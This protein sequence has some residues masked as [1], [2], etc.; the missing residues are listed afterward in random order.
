[1]QIDVRD[2]LFQNN[3]GSLTAGA[4]YM[5]GAGGGGNG[6]LVGS[7]LSALRCQFDG[8]QVTAVLGGKGG[9]VELSPGHEA[10]FT[11]SSFTGN[12]AHHGGAML[13]DQAKVTVVSSTFTNNIGHTQAP[14][15]CYIGTLGTTVWVVDTGGIFGPGD[16]V[17]FV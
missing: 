13:V 14:T 2:T 3:R 15:I 10:L 8:N 11:E 5:S 6:P 9:A 17:Q 7:Y 1:M 12:V 16:V 4:I